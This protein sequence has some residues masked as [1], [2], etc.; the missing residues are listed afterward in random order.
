ME[1]YLETSGDIHFSTNQFGDLELTGT[2]VQ[3]ESATRDYWE[4]IGVGGSISSRVE[5]AHDTIFFGACD[6][7]FYALTL[8][9]KEKWRFPTNGP[10]MEKAGSSPDSVFFGSADGNV[11]ALTLEGKEKW[12]FK[13][14]GICPQPPTYHEGRVYVGSTDRNLYCLEA[15]SGR[16]YWSFRV[17][18]GSI[19]EPIVMD[20]R[21]TFVAKDNIVYCINLDGKLIWTFPTQGSCNIPQPVN[22][23]MVFGCWDHNVYCVNAATGKLVWK[24]ATHG[25]AGYASPWKG[26]IYVMSWDKNVY[27]LDAATG[28]KLWTFPVKNYPSF[29]VPVDDGI[30]AIGTYDGDIYGVDAESGRELWNYKTQGMIV[31]MVNIGGRVYAGSWD[32][33]LYCLDAKTG[34]LIWKFHT[35]MSTP[36]QI[37]PPEARDNVTAQV[38][39]QQETPEEKE[40]R[41]QMQ[42]SGPG[43]ESQYVAKHT[44]I[45]QSKYT[46]ARKIKTMSSGFED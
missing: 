1:K 45:Q 35:S 7:I 8:D 29:E 19:L 26:K 44:Y 42:S 4:R 18:D 36:S 17:K 6:M 46:K 12:R 5:I 27:C 40:D 2:M 39:F 9:G 21:I 20:N 24:T 14:Q 38:V 37:D 3:Y 23:N 28:R 13:T 31:Q 34:K 30:C 25:P 16:K 41:Y 10:I 11:Y 22:G 15:E 33:N 32:C 43:L